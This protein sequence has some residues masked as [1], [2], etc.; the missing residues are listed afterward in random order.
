MGKIIYGIAGK[1]ILIGALLICRAPNQAT[2]TAGVN[3][4]FNVNIGPPP[5]VIPEPPEVVMVPGSQVYFVPGVAFVVFFS[6]AFRRVPAATA[7]IGQ[8]PT[9]GRGE[10]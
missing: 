10:P 5:I 2:A 1:V 7:G 4:G 8:R 3:L 9:T 6:T